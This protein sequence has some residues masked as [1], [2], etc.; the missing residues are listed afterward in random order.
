MVLFAGFIESILSFTALHINLYNP[1][2]VDV[3]SAIVIALLLGFVHGITPDE[4]TWPITFSYAVGSYSTKGG[5]KAGL[6][7]STG[8]TIQRAVLSEVAYL[9]LAGIFMTS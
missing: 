8:F 6:I 5:A 2:N 9:A 3:Y 1:Q 4:H 7:F